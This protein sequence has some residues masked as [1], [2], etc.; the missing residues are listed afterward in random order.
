[1]FRYSSLFP[2]L[3]ELAL[4]IA[5][6]GILVAIKNALGDDAEITIVEPTFPD[7]LE[8]FSPLSF[9]DYV[10]ALQAKRECFFDPV[11]SFV[12]RQL[13]QISGMPAAS[14][15]WQVPFVRCD[16][17]QCT[18]AGNASS[19]CEYWTLGVAPSSS[20][21]E[22]GQQRT[23]SFIEYLYQTY[24]VL[25]PSSD[26]S[27]SLPFDHDFVQTFD[28]EQGMISYVTS[29][30]YGTP[31]YPKIAM[32]IVWNGLDGNE[33][34]YAYSLRQNSTIY[35]VPAES[36]RP[37]SVTTPDTS[38]LFDNFANNDQSCPVFPGAAFTGPRQSSCTGQVSISPLFV[39]FALCLCLCVWVG[40]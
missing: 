38:Q 27:G 16:D 15:D 28:S 8:A 39:S 40:G 13:Y 29:A 10:V 12:S 32:G 34:E 4:P 22:L 7:T 31:G 36:A 30:E 21:D 6:V 14:Y 33:K 26:L 20:S 35:N 9:Q 18:E 17:V 23:D 2:Q 25:D 5:F 3:L 1:M 37:A 11:L 19:F 24:P